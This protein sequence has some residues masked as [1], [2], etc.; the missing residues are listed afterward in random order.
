M[1]FVSASQGARPAR[2]GLPGPDLHGE[3]FGIFSGCVLVLF[4]AMVP[5]VSLL[6]GIPIVAE[7]P[8]PSQ[9]T[10][11]ALV[12]SGLLIAVGLFRRRALPVCNLS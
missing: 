6:V 12:T 10:G 11:L 1:T 9:L 8:G 2:R 7:I 3:R 5:A 4:P